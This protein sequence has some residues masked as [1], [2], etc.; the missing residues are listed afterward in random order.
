MRRH[1]L[2]ANAIAADLHYGQDRASDYD[3]CDSCGRPFDAE[4]G[5]DCDGDEEVATQ[6]PTMFMFCTDCGD[7]MEDDRS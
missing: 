3:F 5:D 2:D 7:E 4:R 1:P 6:H